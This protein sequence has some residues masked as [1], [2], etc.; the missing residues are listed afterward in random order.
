[1]RRA[2]SAL[3]EKRIFFAHASVGANLLSGLGHWFAEHP[4]LRL[5]LVE[6]EDP[7]AL[8]PGTWVHARL[9]H[10]GDPGRKLTRLRE[11]ADGGIAAHA[12]LVLFK[13]CYVDVGAQTPID[14][15]FGR[16][17]EIFTALRERHPR[18]GFALMTVPLTAAP[19]GPKAWARRLLGRPGAGAEDNLHRQALN[20]R[21]RR[22]EPEL[23]DLAWLESLDAEGQPASQMHRGLSVP[24]LADCNTD[25]GGHLNATAQL[26]LARALVEF[27]AGLGEAALTHEGERRA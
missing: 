23:F 8:V 17:R 20:Q 5:Q 9:G 19:R 25:D 6:S 18:T 21:L 12:D 24:V 10:N 27:A 15:L 7:A 16:I 2:L 22:H 3:R 26:R 4:D 13:L 1:M 14:A 11:L